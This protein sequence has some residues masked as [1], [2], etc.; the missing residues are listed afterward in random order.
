MVCFVKICLL[1]DFC[2]CSEQA[3]S[4]PTSNGGAPA[5]DRG[6]LCHY[7]DGELGE[8]RLMAAGRAG[9]CGLGAV[10]LCGEFGIR[11]RCRSPAVDRDESDNLENFWNFF[12]IKYPEIL[13]NKWAWHEQQS[14]ILPVINKL[15]V[16][17][18]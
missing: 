15:T 7:V 10:G 5:L 14:E 1:V 13:L 16:F 4:Q 2:C 3:R 11:I 17:L 6:A 12:K 8:T 9:M 18:V